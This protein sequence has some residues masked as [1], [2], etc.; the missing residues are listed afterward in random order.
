MMKKREGIEER[1]KLR[2]GKG[3]DANGGKM[4]KKGEG[5][6]RRRCRERGESKGRDIV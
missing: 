1:K 2:R 6:K 4:R 5:E 3:R